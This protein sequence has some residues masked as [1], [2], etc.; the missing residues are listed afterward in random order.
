MKSI[1][2]INLNILL[3]NFSNRVLEYSNYITS[4]NTE[5]STKTN[6]EAKNITQASTAITNHRIIIASGKKNDKNHKKLNINQLNS[7]ICD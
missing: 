2:N 1:G 5:V 3:D 7:K 6:K 4:E